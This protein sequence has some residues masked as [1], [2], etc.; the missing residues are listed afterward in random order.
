MQNCSHILE[1]FESCCFKLPG[2]VPSSP[3]NSWKCI[4]PKSLP[5][6]KAII[7][8]ISATAHYHFCSTCQ[9]FSSNDSSCPSLLLPDTQSSYRSVP[10]IR[11]PFSNLS[12]STKRRGCL[13]AGCD[14][15]SRDYALPCLP[16]LWILASF[17]RCHSTIETLNPTV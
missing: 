14:I 15:F 2:S 16:V 13:Y 10:Q 17:L 12:L 6:P 5:F 9:T 4:K 7:T 8:A 3:G 11:P 1:Y